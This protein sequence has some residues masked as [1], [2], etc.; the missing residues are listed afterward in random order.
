[1]D[2]NFFGIQISL[3]F[4]FIFQELFEMPSYG[5]GQKDLLV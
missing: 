5:K 2:F 3:S 4:N 1:M